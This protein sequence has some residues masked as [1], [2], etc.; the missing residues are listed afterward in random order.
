MKVRSIISQREKYKRRTK[1]FIKVDNKEKGE[2]NDQDKIHEKNKVK[3][4]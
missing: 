2:R 4:L 3:E 1:V